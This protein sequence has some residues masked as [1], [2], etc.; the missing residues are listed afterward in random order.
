MKRIFMF[1]T[2]T[3]KHLLTL[4]LENRHNGSDKYGLRNCWTH[5]VLT[6]HT[7]NS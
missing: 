1:T 7:R 6:K 4:Q 3:S 5:P 2:H